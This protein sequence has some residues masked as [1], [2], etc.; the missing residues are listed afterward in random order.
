M[1]KKDLVT[2]LYV[3]NYDSQ[4]YKDYIIKPEQRPIRRSTIKGTTRRGSSIKEKTIRK[5]N[6]ENIIDNKEKIEEEIK[7]IKEENGKDMENQDNI[8]DNNNQEIKNKENDL[9]DENNNE[10][11]ETAD[12]HQN[13]YKE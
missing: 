10:R 9:K 8:V 2:G 1:P 11:I 7:Q 13:E 4:F 12:T 5:K 6:N 3:P